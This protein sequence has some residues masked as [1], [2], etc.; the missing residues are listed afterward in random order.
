MMAENTPKSRADRLMQYR[1]KKGCPSPNPAGRPRQTP[2]KEAIKAAC[3]PERIKKIV[4]K[5]VQMAEEGDL[6]AVEFVRVHLDGPL[7]LP[8]KEADGETE[9]GPVVFVSGLPFKRLPD[10]EA[11][12]FEP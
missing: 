5:V 1:W 12:G 8:L 3:S 6:R 2:I 7:P 10:A 9:T 11:E 4:D